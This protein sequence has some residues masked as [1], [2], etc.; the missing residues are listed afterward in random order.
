M[1]ASFYFLRGLAIG[2]FLCT[3]FMAAYGFL[4]TARGYLSEGRECRRQYGYGALWL[5]GS[6]GVLAFG[7]GAAVLADHLR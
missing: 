7:V 2:C 3:L 4:L 5:L 6:V 1:S